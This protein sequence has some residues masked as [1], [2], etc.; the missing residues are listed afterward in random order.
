MSAASLAAFS[1][2]W[3]TPPE[4]S[5]IASFCAVLARIGVQWKPS[6]IMDHEGVE[7]SNLLMSEFPE[8]AEC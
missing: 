5:G 4:V 6:T 3:Q 8:S 2:A 7:S 1:F